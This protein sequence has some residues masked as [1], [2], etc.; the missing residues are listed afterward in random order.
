[1]KAHLLYRDKDCSS[2][3]ALPS[4]AAELIQDLELDVVFD[5][6]AEGD[7]FIRDLVPSIF[8]GYSCDLDMI[9]Y[10]Q[11]ILSDCIAN[12]EII[13]SL[14][15]LSHEAIENSKKYHFGF[16]TRYPSS[17]L[18][19][20]VEAIRMFSDKLSHLR[21]ITDTYKGRFKSE[22]FSSLFSSIH[23]EIS[24]EYLVKLRTCLK[25]MEFN[26]GVL[27]SAGLAQG[28]RGKDYVLRALPPRKRGWL[29]RFFE[30]R[31]AA[32]SF[33][34]A[35]RDESGA[36]ALSELRDRGIN[37]AADAVARSTEHLLDFFTALKTE[38]AF[39]VGCLNLHEKIGHL[40]LPAAFPGLY[41][42]GTSRRSF[43]RLYDLSLAL[44]SQSAVIGNDMD[45]ESASLYI[46]TGANQGG[47][48]TFLRSIGQAQSM[49]QCGMFVAASSFSAEISNALFTHFRRPE[50]PAMKS[51]KFDEE[52]KRM[53]GIVNSIR[54]NCLL[55]C[56]ES[57]SATNEREGS[58]IAYQITTALVDSRVRVFFV[59]HQYEF[60][61]RLFDLDRSDFR[62]LKAGRRPDG[63][64]SF[65][66]LEG[67]PAE[68][69]F[70]I[71]LF[72]SIF[73]DAHSPVSES[74]LTLPCL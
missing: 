43:R 61:R 25:D 74:S 46:I 15:A 57:F 22:G 53:S 39:Y 28:N 10:R 70:G 72:K 48:T 51:G 14:Y 12:P 52:L 2:T 68:T 63:S 73:P 29:G 49:A 36:R 65:L 67:E 1:M 33:T 26:R 7:N 38:L 45:S 41:E 17:I 42:A 58:E 69:G 16:F 32:Y 23:S 40:G 27:L 11:T 24:D 20:A 54:P 13:R 60:A 59:T 66:I 4:N 62:F 5:A 19:T 56:N 55:L 31:P 37:L 8:L 50:D 3:Q 64:R 44:T 30:R 21:T 34:I 18:R 71:D 9:R 6:M 47:K 35:D